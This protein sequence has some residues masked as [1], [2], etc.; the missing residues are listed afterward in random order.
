MNCEYCHIEFNTKE[1]FDAHNQF[2]FY[3]NNPKPKPKNKEEKPK[4]KAKTKKK[5]EK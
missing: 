2:C 4:P 3:K 5:Q 1:G